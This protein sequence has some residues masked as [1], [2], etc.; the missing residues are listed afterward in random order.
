MAPV[1]PVETK[2]VITQMRCEDRADAA[3]LTVPKAWSLT[4]V[5]VMARKQPFFSR[6]IPAGRRVAHI[7]VERIIE[8][9]D[10]SDA[11]LYHFIEARMVLA[12]V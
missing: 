10:A 4:E 6:L 2:L 5:A 8:F 11:L 12:A 3:R 9:R 7:V 1:A